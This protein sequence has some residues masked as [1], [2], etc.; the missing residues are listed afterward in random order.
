MGQPP[1]PRL[2]LLLAVAA[3]DPVRVIARSFTGTSLDVS[4]TLDVE[5]NASIRDVKRLLSTKLSGGPPS[6]MLRLLHG[7]VELKDADRVSS[8]ADSADETPI[9]LLLGS[10]PPATDHRKIPQS[11]PEQVAAY[12]AEVAAIEYTLR[13]LSR[14]RDDALACSTVGERAREIVA[15]IEST[16]GEEI[17]RYTETLR[18]PLATGRLAA[19]EHPPAIL[20]V[21]GRAYHRKRHLPL[22]LELRR[23]RLVLGFLTSMFTLRVV[24]GDAELDVASFADG[25]YLASYF[26]SAALVIATLRSPPVRRTTKLAL[27]SLPWKLS[28]HGIPCSTSPQ[29]AVASVLPVPQQA[30]LTLDENAFSRDLFKVL[31]GNSSGISS[32]PGFSDDESLKI[33]AIFEKFDADGS[34]AIDKAEFRAALA[35]LHISSSD[36]DFDRLFQRYDADGSGA[37]ELCE[38]ARLAKPTARTR[39]RRTLKGVR[40]AVVRV[41]MLH[42][43]G[44][45]TDAGSMSINPSRLLRNVQR[46]LHSVSLPLSSGAL[47]GAIF[48]LLMAP[49][50]ADIWLHAGI[51]LSR[52]VA[53]AL[54]LVESI[55]LF[56]QPV[57]GALMGAVDAVGEKRVLAGV[58]LLIFA[59][60]MVRSRARREREHAAADLGFGV[61]LDIEE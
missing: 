42:V 31:L 46:L 14:P 10:L 17:A 15:Q 34:G 37:L 24:M 22:G 12:A 4:R 1:F 2:L 58:G 13:G 23:L 54:C 11:L 52:K 30:R 53:H 26:T 50:V 47:H 60:N 5:H 48:G 28:P 8:L 40:G 39:R 21:G 57:L 38:F 29:D 32:S 43:L 16:H 7:T 56:A 9:V 3:A 61:G 27:Y 18:P 36:A 59:S 19:S 41:V 25:G 6:R 55:A 51:I 35:Y 45:S 44:L 20:S 49:L 33:T